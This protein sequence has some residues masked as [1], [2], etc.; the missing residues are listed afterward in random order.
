MAVPGVGV[1]PVGIV[2][3]FDCKKGF[4]FVVDDAGQDVFIHYT[5]I[6]GEGFRRLRDGERIEYEVT[7]GPKGLSA[8]HVR[9][10]ETAAAEGEPA[11]DIPK[12]PAIG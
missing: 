11:G 9:R 2:K 4:G 3:W 8:I 6:E 1:M 7:Q 5:V 12:T 10:L